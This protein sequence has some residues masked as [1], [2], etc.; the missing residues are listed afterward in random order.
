M[1]DVICKPPA[2]YTCFAMSPNRNVLLAGLENGS[3]I[4]FGSNYS[5]LC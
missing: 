1:R 5:L 2:A 4:A 3:M